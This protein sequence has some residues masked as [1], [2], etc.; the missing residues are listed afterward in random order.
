MLVIWIFLIVCKR[1]RLIKILE[2]QGILTIKIRFRS[3]VIAIYFDHLYW[4]VACPLKVLKLAHIVKQSL[5]GDFQYRLTLSLRRHNLRQRFTEFFGGIFV[6]ISLAC[7]SLFLYCRHINYPKVCVIWQSPHAFVLRSIV[8]IS[9]LIVHVEIHF[10][11]FAVI[12]FVLVDRQLTICQWIL[13]LSHF[14]DL[15]ILLA[16]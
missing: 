1:Y 15:D 14:S 16:L 3:E 8:V 5:L 4:I 9:S 12:I 11:N 2:G 7:K 13:I 6:F 10:Y